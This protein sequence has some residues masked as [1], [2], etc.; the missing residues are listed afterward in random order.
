MGGSEHRNRNTATKEKYIN[1]HR[2][3]TRTA[4]YTI[5]NYTLSLG[6]TVPQHR[7]LVHFTK[8]HSVK[9]TN[10]AHRRV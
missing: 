7:K 9:N 8:H 1:E 10:I 2:I 4:C 3:I 6:L 5:E